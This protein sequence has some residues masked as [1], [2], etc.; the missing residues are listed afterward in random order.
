MSTS[1]VSLG[2]RTRRRLCRLRTE[3]R[4][5]VLLEFSLILLMLLIFIFGIV[6]FGRALYT[7]NSLNLA[8]REGARFAAVAPNP[9]G[10]VA[11]IR[12]TTIAHMSPFGG[13]SIQP[14][15]VTVTFEY[16]PGRPAALQATTVQVAYP[17]P[18]ITPIR[19]LLGL[20]ELTLH[21]SARYR[22]ELGG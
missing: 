14:N 12:D 13:A 19:P 9:T 20:P 4:G 21:A 11:A 10:S 17:F 1:A 3:E 8:V 16:A 6:D 2:S 22:W 7:A 18:L 5:T 15:Q